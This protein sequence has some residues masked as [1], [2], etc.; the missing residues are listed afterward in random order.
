MGKDKRARADN[1]LTA[2]ALANLVAAIVDTMRNTDLPDDI[3]R[4]FIEELDRLNT[5]MLPPTG[6]GAF[7][8]FVTDVLRGEVAAN[9]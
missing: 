7:M 5:L 1:R 8:H 6:A 9:D 4:H 2:I 3:V